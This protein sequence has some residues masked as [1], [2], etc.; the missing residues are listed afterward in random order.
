MSL[1]DGSVQ[2]QK[3]EY[4]AETLGS[5]H[6]HG[7]HASRSTWR[8]QQI[9]IN[10]ARLVAVLIIVLITFVPVVWIFLTGFKSEAE[11]L[12]SPPVW[13]PSKPSWTNYID[14]W[15]EGGFEALMNSLIVTIAGCL[16]AMVCGV[17]AA[18]SLSRFRTGGQNLANWILSIK[19]MP[20]I[21]FTIPIAVMFHALRLIDTH[22]G[23]ILVYGTFNL[24]FVVWTMKG[25]I[26]EIPREL[27]ESVMIDGCSRLGA[28]WW[29]ALP[30]SAPGLV[31]T[32]LMTFIFIWSEFLFALILSQSQLFTVP[33][34]LSQYYSEAVGLKWGPQAALATVA[35]LPMVA[36]A[37]IGQRY[38]VRALT[39]GAVK[40]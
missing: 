23:L 21:A 28:M 3:V 1:S 13:L 19:F 29:I 2:T 6:K 38:I 39:F 27:D 17:P 4:S 12:A 9:L 5:H 26:D 37:F 20:A 25:F 32:I 33:V 15:H 14:M 18:Y 16:L 40:D 24:P 10:S 31:T 22:S 7:V 35:I 36:I 8:R 30:L 11:Y 34:R